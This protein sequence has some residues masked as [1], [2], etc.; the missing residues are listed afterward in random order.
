MTKMQ[1]RH[2]TTTVSRNHSGIDL[3]SPSGRILSFPICFTMD[4]GGLSDSFWIGLKPT[5]GRKL[6]LRP[7]IPRFPPKRRPTSRRGQKQLRQYGAWS[8]N[9]IYVGGII[10]L[11]SSVLHRNGSTIFK[12]HWNFP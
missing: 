1:Q 6:T 4:N 5:E 9:P 8:V 7:S 11:I 10:Q 2:V 12:A 3:E